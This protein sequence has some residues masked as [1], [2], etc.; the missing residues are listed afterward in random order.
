MLEFKSKEKASRMVKLLLLSAL[1]SIILSAVYVFVGMPLNGH[2]MYSLIN[3][4]AVVLTGV[5][6]VTVF[7]LFYWMH[8]KDL[9]ESFAVAIN[10]LYW[11]GLG[12]Q[13]L[14]VY[15]IC[16]PAG[17]CSYPGG[18]PWLDHTIHGAMASFLGLESATLP[19]L[20]IWVMFSTAVMV[21]VNYL[22]YRVEA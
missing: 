11:L 10:V 5:L 12:S 13:D 9:S 3:T 4:Y 17:K 1:P 6:G 8:H 2:E 15:L 22:I 14:F 7:P 20:F 18:M 16:L 19:L 21:V